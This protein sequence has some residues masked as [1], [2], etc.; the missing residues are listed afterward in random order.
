MFCCPRLHESFRLGGNM[1]FSEEPKEG[2]PQPV[3]KLEDYV[4]RIRAGWQ[5]ITAQVLEV[6]AMCQ[7]ADK[8]LSRK[9]KASLRKALGISTTKFSMLVQIGDD[10]RLRKEEVKQLL[11]PNFSI[12]YT[13]TRL[14]EAEFDTAV[15]GKV[16]RP[17]V[18]RV[19]LE[20][21][22]GMSGKQ[23]EPE[24]VSE[25]PED[26]YVAIRLMDELSEESIVALEERLRAIMEEFDVQLIRNDSAIKKRASNRLTKVLACMRFDARIHIEE[27]ITMGNL[28][29]ELTSELGSDPLKE[30]V[31]LS[32]DADEAEIQRVLDLVG[33]GNRFK[34]IR[35]K[36]NAQY[37]TAKIV[38]HQEV[39]NSLKKVE[40]AISSSR[41]RRYERKDFEKLT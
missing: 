36:A 28:P 21:L 17:N 32:D 2:L 26:F 40:Q 20:R 8:N 38:R 29:E 24:I 37:P 1:D 14:N 6:A 30:I 18:K 25:L 23:K 27:A 16:L 5:K 4:A 3:S 11:P 15:R 31:H 22:R 39:M 33:K 7:E 9:D 34:D 13:L 10:P 41:K 19:E 35:A 12:L